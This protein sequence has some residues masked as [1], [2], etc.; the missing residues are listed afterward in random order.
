MKVLQINNICGAGSTGMICTSIA[1]LLEKTGNNSII[2]YSY[3]FC[4]LPNTFKFSK[5]KLGYYIHNFF[6]R[7]FDNEGLWSYIDT[8]R[9]I[10]YINRE[11]PDI[12]HIHNLHGHYVNYRILIDHMNKQKLPIVIT[13]HDCWLLTGHCAH[14]ESLGCNKWE[15]GCN[16]CHHLS[17]YPKSYF[18]D[19]SKRNFELKK[20]IFASINTNLTIVPV[21]MWLENFVK[22]SYLKEKKTVMIHNGIDLKKFSYNVDE[23]VLHKYKLKQDNYVLGVALPWSKYKGFDDMLKLSKVFPNSL[24]IV[25][26]GLSSDQLKHLPYNVVGIGRTQNINELVTLY[27]GALSFINTTYSDTYPTVNLEALACGTPVVT[28][29]TGGSIESVTKNTGYIVE[30]GNID[31]I[32]ISILKLQNS[33]RDTIRKECLDWASKNCDMKEC[34]IKYIELYNKIFNSLK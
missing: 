8:Y 5:G 32:I 22:R 23:N 11:K 12:V 16:N 29:K 7:L 30:Q 25:L 9:L 24:K 20:S 31:E 27:S 33:D 14:F 4:P 28:Y 3:G 13:M 19:N 6:S 2:A 26:V 17:T 18:F 34:Y 21:S 1:K 15:T 10:S